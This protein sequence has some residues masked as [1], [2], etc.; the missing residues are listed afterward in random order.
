MTFHQHREL[1]DKH[2][3]ALASAIPAPEPL[4]APIRDALTSPG[5]RVRALLTISVGEAVGCRAAKLLDAAAAMEMI[6][7]S[8][9]ILDDLLA[10]DDA[11]MRRGKPTLHRAYGEDLAIL[12]AVAL[13]NH[14]YGLVSS[15]HALLSPRR[16]TAVDV[17]HRV[18]DA[19]GWD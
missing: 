18:V 19:V 6:H 3:G 1:I 17:M 11:E 13:L 15:N 9:L 12:A 8:S 5:K 2:L 14:A 7:A 4:A 16:W 10:M